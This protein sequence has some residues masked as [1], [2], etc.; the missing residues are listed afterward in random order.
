MHDELVEA[1]KRAI[2]TD[3]FSTQ[4][5]FQPIP[6]VFTEHSI[7]RGGNVLGLDNVK[8]DCLM[9]LIVG[10]T[11]TTGQG[12][13]MRTSLEILYR[14]LGAYATSLNLRVDWQYLNYV[15]QMQDPLQSYGKMNVDFMRKVSAEYDPSGVF[16]SKIISGWKL[17]NVH[18]D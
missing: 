18:H 2:P 16:Q 3:S 17:S 15:D 14:D 11:K 12:H 13:I 4:C 7:H 6:T 8:R 10:S 1:L 9:W 5:L